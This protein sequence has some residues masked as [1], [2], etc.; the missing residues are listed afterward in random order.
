MHCNY[1]ENQFVNIPEFYINI[2]KSWRIIRNVQP[3]IIW[4]NQEFLIKG[5]PIFCKELFQAGL[6]YMYDMYDINEQVIPF[7]VWQS[8]GV[9]NTAY[10]IILLWRGLVEICA[11]FKKQV[12]NKIEDITCSIR[13]GSLMLK[14]ISSKVCYNIFKS[15][16]KF[17]L[18]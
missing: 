16:V 17:F 6:W 15:K 13:N 9:K 7:N 2:L 18:W 12:C 5:K 3:E 14:D 1:K 4:N 8:R 11:K 10:M